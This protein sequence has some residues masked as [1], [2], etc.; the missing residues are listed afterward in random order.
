MF[1]SFNTKRF[2]AGMAAIVIVVLAVYVVVFLEIRSTNR[3]ISIF[4][5]EIDLVLQ[6]ENRLRS[7]QNILKKSTTQRAQINTYFVKEDAVVD[8]IETIE[9]IG[10]LTN[11]ETDI[12]SVSI[13]DVGRDSDI[14]ELL[15]ITFSTTGTWEG[16]FHMLALTEALPFKVVLQQVRFE[17]ISSSKV[18][19]TKLDK[20]DKNKEEIEKPIW[21]ATFDLTVLKLKK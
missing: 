7:I 10:I 15:R 3:S 1:E 11:T 6:K 17:N 5:N 13:D 16:V 2:V 19:T 18:E 14:G 8:F 9:N 21:E 12:T 20:S 4:A